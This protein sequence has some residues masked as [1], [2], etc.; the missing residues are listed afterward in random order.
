MSLF[1]QLC[2]GRGAYKSIRWT[3]TES[4]FPLEPN[5]HINVAKSC[6]WLVVC[7]G[8]VLSAEPRG[9]CTNFGLHS[10]GKFNTSPCSQL[11]RYKKQRLQCIVCAPCTQ[12]PEPITDQRN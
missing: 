11:S 7:L 5:A 2:L 6:P 12:H 4:G 9:S 10:E 3:K 8:C 1:A